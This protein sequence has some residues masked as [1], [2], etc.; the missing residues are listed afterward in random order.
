M[1][2]LPL[3]SEVEKTTDYAFIKSIVL[4][5]VPS[6][7]VKTESPMVEAMVVNQSN[8]KRITLLGPKWTGKTACLVAI[9]TL[10]EANSIHVVSKGIKHFKRAVV[11]D[12]TQGLRQRYR[13]EGE[14]TTNIIATDYKTAADYAS[15]LCKFMEYL[16]ARV[17]DKVLLLI[18][19]CKCDVED[20]KITIWHTFYQE[21]NYRSLLSFCDWAW[22]NR[23]Y[24]HINWIPLFVCT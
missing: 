3:L 1:E 7:Y 19:L 8:T 23:E 21:K 20:D 9:W 2:I 18:D 16:C 15:Y 4:G 17:D 12:F 14:L 6:V 22:E 13:Q 24:L 11:K 10:C 5:N